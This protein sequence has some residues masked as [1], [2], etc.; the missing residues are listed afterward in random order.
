VISLLYFFVF[1]E[2]KFSP[3]TRDFP[4][5]ALIVTLAE[6]FSKKDKKLAA[7]ANTSFLQLC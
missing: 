4:F 5:N 7:T 3:L 1:E 6:N 2:R